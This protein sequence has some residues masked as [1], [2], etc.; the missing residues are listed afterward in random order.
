MMYNCRELPLGQKADLTK[1]SCIL[2]LVLE[3][4][5]V[6]VPSDT[7]EVNLHLDC[8][9]ACAVAEERRQKQVNC[10][11]TKGAHVELPDVVG[12][13]SEDDDADIVRDWSRPSRRSSA[14]CKPHAQ[15]P[16]PWDQTAAKQHV[17]PTHES[18]AP[19]EEGPS[20]WQF[21]EL[22]VDHAEELDRRGA[23]Q[24]EELASPRVQH[25]NAVQPVQDCEEAGQTMRQDNQ[26]VSSSALGA[27]ANVPGWN[28]AQAGL[29]STSIGQRV[30][31][32]VGEVVAAT[33]EHEQRFA[34]RLRS[35][36]L[37]SRPRELNVLD[38][39][40]SPSQ[41][42]NSRPDDVADLASTMDE[43]SVSEAAAP[44]VA[45]VTAER[46]LAGTGPASGAVREPSEASSADWVSRIQS[47]TSQQLGEWLARVKTTYRGSKE[48][49]LACSA[50]EGCF[51]V[52]C[53]P[54]NAAKMLLGFYM[55][56]RG[57]DQFCGLL[58][59]AFE[60]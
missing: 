38:G 54:A 21:K 26:L 25:S 35:N 10:K 60:V 12:A 9:S 30:A 34:G 47:A 51:L 50:F 32:F 8:S 7:V 5:H 16:S 1:Q 37:K 53:L 55:I 40:P 24:M 4:G 39:V 23:L 45:G 48:V 31:S 29:L 56:R 57:S 46:T 28:L 6:F 36:S 42:T 17:I 33:T 41:A 14:I 18:E 52:T 19:D 2:I 11:E 43:R 44:N 27:L 13:V 49:R 59:Q 3:S 58:K 15:G 20:I 22:G